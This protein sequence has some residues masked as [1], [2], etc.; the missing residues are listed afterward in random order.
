MIAP[1][2]LAA[3]PFTLVIA[4]SPAQGTRVCACFVCKPAD[5]QQVLRARPGL[6]A[7][8]LC[9]ETAPCPSPG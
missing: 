4:A 1:R 9:P 7:I 3:P 6:S 8:M 5:A 2:E